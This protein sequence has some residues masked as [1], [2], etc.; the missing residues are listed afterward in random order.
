MKLSIIIPARNEQW[1]EKT[2]EDIN[3]HAEGDF[4]VLVGNDVNGIGQRAMMNV[5]AK[6][7]TG[8]YIM[9]TDG[10]CSFSQGF[11]IKLLAEIDDKTILAPLLLPL[12]ADNWTVNGKKQMAQFVFDEN[13]VMQHAEG[14]VGET[15]V[16]QGCCWVVSKE[17]YWKWNLCDESFGSWGMQSLELGIKAYLNGGVC[18]TTRSAYVGHLFRHKD[19]EFPYPRGDNPGQFANKE[20][21]RRY[22]N[23]SIAGLIKKFN[24][25]CGWTKEIVDNLPEI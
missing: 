6:Q 5:L 19:E 12:D 17:N 3:Q 11:D 21:K 2:V 25:P 4:E 18:R 16:H 20:M 10:H 14:D 23:K 24:Y 22:Y 13:F 8:D 7:A 9:K 1:L 15:M